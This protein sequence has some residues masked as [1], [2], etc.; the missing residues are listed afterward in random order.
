MKKLLILMSAVLLFAASPAFA[1]PAPAVLND[2][3]P[4][5]TEKIKASLQNLQTEFDQK[6]L[7][8]VTEV[9]TVVRKIDQEMTAAKAEELSD[10]QLAQLTAVQKKLD[11][12]LTTQVMI[13]LKDV[14]IEEVNKELKLTGENALT[15]E[16]LIAQTKFMYLYLGMVYFEQNK[17]LPEED[18]ELLASLFFAE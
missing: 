15:K 17:K 16:K 3:N 13:R 1:L 12:V 10:S 8:A 6:L 9:V 14:N 2:T 5:V 7:P 11:N 18:I 4:N